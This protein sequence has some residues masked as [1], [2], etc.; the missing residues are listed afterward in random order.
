[1]EA[2]AIYCQTANTAPD[3]VGV[4]KTM[5][6]LSVQIVKFVLLNVVILNTHKKSEFSTPLHWPSK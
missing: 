4:G 6:Y 3:F 1:M 5:R 2:R